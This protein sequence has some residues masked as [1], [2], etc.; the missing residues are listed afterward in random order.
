MDAIIF[1]QEYKRMCGQ[2]NGRCEP[3]DC[4]IRVLLDRHR[5]ETCDDAFIY[6]HPVEVVEAIAEWSNTHP[7]HTI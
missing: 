7:Q 3:M 6:L 4:Q 2:N 1:L 5:I